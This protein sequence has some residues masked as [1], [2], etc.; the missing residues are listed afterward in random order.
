MADNGPSSGFVEREHIP[1][2]KAMVRLSERN[3][4][5]K[6]RPEKRKVTLCP[7]CKGKNIPYKKILHPKNKDCAGTGVA[8]DWR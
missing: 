2:L 3:K 1:L 8:T 5:R 4:G 6:M 7:Y